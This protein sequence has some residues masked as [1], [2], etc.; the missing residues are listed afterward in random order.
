M[1]ALACLA[2]LAFVTAPIWYPTW[3][4][5]R[6][7]DAWKHSGDDQ[8]Y[9]APAT[10]PETATRREDT[11]MGMFSKGKDA[12]QKH[13][14]AQDRLDSYRGKDPAEFDR[15]TDAVIEAEKD[16]SYARRHGWL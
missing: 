10:G 4:A 7:I 14:T 16:V 6:V 5:N 8:R 3:A 15:L 1:G 11:D 2:G 12:I 13:E 9:A